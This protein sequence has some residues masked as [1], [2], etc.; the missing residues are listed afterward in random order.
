[1]GFEN[2]ERKDRQGHEKTRA[3]GMGSFHAPRWAGNFV[4]EVALFRI[5]KAHSLGPSPRLPF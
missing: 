5:W 4:I 3:I 2:R 1:M